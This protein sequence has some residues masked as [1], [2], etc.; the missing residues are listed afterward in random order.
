SDMEDVAHD[1]KAT[2]EIVARAPWLTMGYLNN[3][4]ASEQLWAGGYMHTGDVGAISPD[5]TLHVTDRLKDI[6]KSGGEWI[7]SIELEDIIMLREG[8]AKAAVIA[9]HDDKWGERPLA[10]GN[11]L[12]EQYRDQLPAGNMPAAAD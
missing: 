1:G 10:L 11:V 3:P 12:R 7:S 9:V 6:I 2:G 8:V 4:E 5:G